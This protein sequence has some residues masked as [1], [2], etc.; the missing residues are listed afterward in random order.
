VSWS[1]TRPNVVLRIRKFAP[2]VIPDTAGLTD[3]E[4]AS[5]KA[6]REKECA[7]VEPATEYPQWRRDEITEKYRD[8]SDFG[9][10]QD[11]VADAVGIS[12]WREL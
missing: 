1:L 9:D 8:D 2:E 10:W 3:D 12:R 4:R 6:K 11:D 5:H 7:K